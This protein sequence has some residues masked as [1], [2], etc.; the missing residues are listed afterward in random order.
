MMSLRAQQEQPQAVYKML[1]EAGVVV[2]VADVERW[3]KIFPIDSKEKLEE[4]NYMLHDITGN[5]GVRS[6]RRYDS[7]Q[8][9]C[10]NIL[11]IIIYG[12][13]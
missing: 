13:L 5:S 2:T 6:I 8:L 7:M 9:I 10:H 11:Y 4:V 1:Q 12:I 3:D